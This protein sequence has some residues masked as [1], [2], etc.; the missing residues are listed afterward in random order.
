LY[1]PGPWLKPGANQII[2]FD[3]L[4]DSSDALRDADKPS[5]DRA[6]AHRE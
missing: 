5:F 1:L 3:L 6:L 2:F 4:S